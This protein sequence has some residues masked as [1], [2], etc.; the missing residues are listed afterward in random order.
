VEVRIPDWGRVTSIDPLSYELG[1]IIRMYGKSMDSLQSLGYEDC[2]TLFVAAYDWRQMPTEQWKNDVRELIEKAVNSTG[3]KA[4]IVSHSMGCPFSYMTLM[5]QSFEWRQKYIHHY[6]PISPVWVGTNI[7]PFTMITNKILNLTIRPFN[8]LGKI[9][10]FI[11]GTYLLNPSYFY[12][13]D[14]LIAKTDINI[15]TARNLSVLLER[16]GVK[17]AE[18]LVRY[19]QEQ[20]YQYEYEHPGIPITTIWSTGANT[21]GPFRWYKDSQVGVDE[22]IPE[23]IEGDGL[24]PHDSLTFAFKVWSNSKYADITKGVP[25]PGTN[26][27]TTC[28]NNNTVYH[29][30][31]AAC[32]SA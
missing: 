24:V 9:F 16:A 30:F 6:V 10:R 2:K 32:D 4:V 22:P 21:V 3:K 31:N 18:A 29:I 7:I 11:Q 17:N 23:F 15:Y 20:L 8:A 28:S 25:L 12:R 26:H 14:V 19:P 5:S 13:P 27:A 1:S